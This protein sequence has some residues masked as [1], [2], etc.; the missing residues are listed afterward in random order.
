M[1]RLS[2]IE[3]QR[4]RNRAVEMF[5]QN[6]ANAD[7]A[8][9]LGLA[10]QTI[11]RWHSAWTKQGQ[12]AL[13]VQERGPKPRFDDEQWQHILDALSEGPRK[14]GFDTELWTLKRIADLIEKMTGVRY[15]L[16]CIHKELKRRNW[17][18]QKPA[19]RARE[20]KDEDIARWMVE[21]WPL[22]KRGRKKPEPD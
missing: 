15:H 8:R 9:H 19:R 1:L 2:K 16:S 3:L 7:I 12:E 4:A 10:R 5:E 6:K 17:S 21:S 14:Q 13:K 20:R 22:I 11:S 18:C